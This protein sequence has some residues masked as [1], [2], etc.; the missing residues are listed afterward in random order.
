MAGG[1]GASGKLF[2][3]GRPINSDSTLGA[4]ANNFESKR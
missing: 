1:I 3:V 2:D 4:A